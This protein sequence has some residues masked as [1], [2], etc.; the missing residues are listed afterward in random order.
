MNKPTP[1][2]NTD[3]I[4]GKTTDMVPNETTNDPTEQGKVS[5][6]RTRQGLYWIVALGL[7]G[8]L[9]GYEYRAVIF[10]S[11]WLLY[12]PLLICGGMHFFMHGGHGRG[13]GGRG[14][15]DGKS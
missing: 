7:G 2:I 5:F 13:H 11:G 4:T 9:L 10:A 1:H 8:V 6:W 3:E 14:S 12:L 15:G